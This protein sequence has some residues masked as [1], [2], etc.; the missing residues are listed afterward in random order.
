MN[1]VGEAQSAFRAADECLPR[2][3]DVY[4]GGPVEAVAKLVPGTARITCVRA[5]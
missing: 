1:D 3:C 4:A 5:A 2:Q